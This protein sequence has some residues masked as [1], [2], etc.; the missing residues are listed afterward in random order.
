MYGFYYNNTATI[1]NL[2][3]KAKKIGPKTSRLHMFVYS[4]KK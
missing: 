3:A 1:K 4:A 2:H